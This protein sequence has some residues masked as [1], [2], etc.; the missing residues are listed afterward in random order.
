MGSRGQK[1]EIKASVD[2]EASAR[3]LVCSWPDVNR[4]SCPNECGSVS[5]LLGH[6]GHFPRD[7]S[8]LGLKMSQHRGRE[9]AGR[10]ATKEG[11]QL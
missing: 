4:K 2:A 3:T 6:Q 10:M 8:E 7:L 1:H 9:D 5:Y 11:G